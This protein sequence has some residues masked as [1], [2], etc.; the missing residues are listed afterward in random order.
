MNF[1]VDIFPSIAHKSGY[2]DFQWCPLCAKLLLQQRANR[3]E[4]GL[5]FQFLLNIYRDYQSPMPFLTLA[6]TCNFIVLL[7]LRKNLVSYLHHDPTNAFN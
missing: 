3:Q 7:R 4:F 2:A 1:E 6:R 5:I